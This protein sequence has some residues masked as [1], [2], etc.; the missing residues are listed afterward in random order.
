MVQQLHE[1]AASLTNYDLMHHVFKEPIV[2]DEFYDYTKR[3]YERMCRDNPQAAKAIPKARSIRDQMLSQGNP[4]RHDFPMLPLLDVFDLSGVK[5]WFEMFDAKDIVIEPSLLG[6]EVEL[7]YVG[8]S[9]HK[10]VNRGDGL[11]GKDITMNM[12]LV[13]GVPQQIPETDRVNIHGKVVISRMDQLETPGWEHC[14]SRMTTA[15]H[16]M[17]VLGLGRPECLAFIPHTVNIPGCPFDLMELRMVLMGWEFNLSPAWVFNGK[18]REMGAIEEGIDA[19]EEKQLKDY[20]YPTDGLT[21][22]V[23]E[24]Q[25]RLEL[26]YTSRYP[27]WAFKY[28][29]GKINEGSG[30]SSSQ[31]ST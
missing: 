31:S 22:R 12:Y 10:A 29:R 3:L 7:V 15:H 24:T 8:G 30:T 19:F 11:E 28:I 1:L 4:S 13:N 20:I 23:N 2:T 26:G 16:L 5:R 17:N 27:E 6:I 18:C 14:D 25:R 21:F 9:L